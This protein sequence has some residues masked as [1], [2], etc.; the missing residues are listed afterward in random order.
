M[1][2]VVDVSPLSIPPTGIGHYILGML[3][4]L[5]EAG[6][7][8]HEVV[9]FAPAGPKSRH[10]IEAALDGFPIE[11][12][13]PLAF[14]YA[15]AWRTA[16]SRLGRPPVET[17]VGPLDVFH[18]SEWMYPAQRAGLRTTTFYDL[19]P[20]RFPN[21]VHPRTLRMH[22]R[23]ARHAADECKLVFAISAFTAGE[24]T[25]LL[26]I[27]S[28]RIV[29]V[30]PGVESHFTPE[31]PKVKRANPYLFAVLDWQPRKNLRRLVKA[32]ELLRARR[33]ELELLVAGTTAEEP[34]PAGVTM[35]GY[36]P[37]DELVRLH[38]GA[39]AFVYPSLYEGFGMPIVE[40]MASGTPTVSSSH[41]SLDEASGDAAVRANPED[42]EAIADGIERALD[43]REALVPRGL[44]HARRFTWRACG[45]AHLHGFETAL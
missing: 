16:W 20:L 25:E 33:P 6:G 12:R 43:E 8:E 44:E 22:T 41:P 36:T 13:L 27:P 45:E 1:R 19:I 4:G 9:A 10:R 40:A 23:K 34:L 26:G 37:T 38:R 42:V 35:L 2:I 14:P 17:L 5:V 31:G 29:V 28:E 24:V 30:H 7:D 3:R 21:W 11:R 15:H 32:F 18:F 39:A